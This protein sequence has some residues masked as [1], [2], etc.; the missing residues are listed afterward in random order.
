MLAKWPD[1][2]YIPRGTRSQPRGVSASPPARRAL[3]IMR[4]TI[5]AN[6]PADQVEL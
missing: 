4:S 6:A 3:S 2:I 1:L 5:T